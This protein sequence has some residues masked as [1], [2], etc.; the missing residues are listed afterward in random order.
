M[1][2]ADIVSRGPASSGGLTRTVLLAILLAFLAQ[3]AVVPANPQGFPLADETLNYSLNFSAGIPIGKAQFTAKR[4]PNRGWNFGFSLDADAIPKYPIIDR[5][6]AY[7]GVDLCGIRFERSTQHGSRKVSE[8]TWFDRTRSVAVRGTR[9]GGG[10]SETPV[11]LCPHDAL[12]FLYYLRREFGQG[13][14]P[15]NDVVLAGAQYHVNMIYAGEKSIVQN[16]QTVATD[17]VNVTV[18]GPASQIRLEILF[19][20]DASRTPLLIR[21]PLTVGNFSLELIR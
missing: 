15:P 8:M 21:C 20:R 12:S 11:G 2:T 3:P 18:K 9:D 16:K 5:F 14:M 10:L 6:N 13:H 7:S 4:D 19:A 1:T 17:Q